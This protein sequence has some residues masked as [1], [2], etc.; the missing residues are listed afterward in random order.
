MEWL[1]WYLYIYTLVSIIASSSAMAFGSVS[2]LFIVSYQTYV[3]G[4]ELLNPTEL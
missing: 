3:S 1:G 4:W 2:L